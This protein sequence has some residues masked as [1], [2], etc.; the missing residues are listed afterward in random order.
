MIDAVTANADPF[1]DVRS[2]TAAHRSR[3]HC[4]AYGYHQ[5][6][7][8]AV[9]AAAAGAARIVEVGTALGYTALWLAYGAP[10]AQV[11]TIEA[12]ADHVRLARDELDRYPEGA[13]VT[14]HHGLAEHVLAELPAGEFD[15][16]FFDGLAPTPAL[17]DGLG[18]RL[19]PGGVLI[20]ANMTMSSGADRLL[21]ADRW[22]LVHDLGETAIAIASG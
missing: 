13:R 22:R 3:H 4:H 8:L 15:V 5:P 19:E 14:V 16:A 1:A 21:G 11:D 18:E 12:D 2:H 20:A 6:T 7:L 9:I 17:V 10:R